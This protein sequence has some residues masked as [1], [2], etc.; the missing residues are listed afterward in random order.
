MW[1]LGNLLAEGGDRLDLRGLVVPD[2]VRTAARA[3]ARTVVRR[4]LLGGCLAM[5]GECSG[6]DLRMRCACTCTHAHMHMHTCTCTHAHAHMH[7]HTC[8]RAHVHTRTHARMH[9][10]YPRRCL[11][12]RASFWS[13][14]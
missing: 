14:T 5:R 10:M 6:V 13:P 7:M 3:I 8:T 1:E 12:R 4:E 2:E 9:A 11:L